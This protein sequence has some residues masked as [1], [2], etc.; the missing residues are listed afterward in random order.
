[1]NPFLRN[2]GGVLGAGV[3][4]GAG[5][6]GKL[7]AKKKEAESKTFMGGF[8]LAPMT[9]PMTA[10]AIVMGAGAFVVA[11]TSGRDGERNSLGDAASGMMWG[12]AL[13]A[14]GYMAYWYADSKMRKMP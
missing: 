2:M 10:A 14:L 8:T 12:G 3:V 6:A 11:A 9:Y 1:M 4:V 13:G 5:I 7:E